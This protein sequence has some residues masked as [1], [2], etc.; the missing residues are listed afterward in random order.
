MRLCQAG[1][2]TARWEPRPQGHPQ[3]RSGA[4]G[5][6]HCSTLINKQAKAAATR[7]PGPVSITPWAAWPTR[8]PLL[9]EAMQGLSGSCSSEHPPW[10]VGSTQTPSQPRALAG[11]VN[12][13]RSWLG[14]FHPDG[15]HLQKPSGFPWGN[16]CFVGSA[17]ET[18]T[19]RCTP[20]SA[21]AAAARQL[22]GGTPSTRLAASP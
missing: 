12:A 18:R 20:R 9:Q 11:L 15:F 8:P 5:Q 1:T 2:E 13:L 21:A 4:P 19:R 3:Q 6:M 16:F 10:A 14:I 7:L 17:R 22:S